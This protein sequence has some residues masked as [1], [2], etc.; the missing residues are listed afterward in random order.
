MMGL[1]RS[2]A[3]HLLIRWRGAVG[4]TEARGEEVK[5]FRAAAAG[6]V[7]ESRQRLLC[8]DRLALNDVRECPKEVDTAVGF[9]VADEQPLQRNLRLAELVF[10]D[11]LLGLDGDSTGQRGGH[12]AE[13]DLLRPS[14]SDGGVV[15]GLLLQRGCEARVV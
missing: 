4:R 13:H 1:K 5:L 11:G 14:E 10:A 7:D 12:L 8:F 2:A 9:L 3:V 15:L 6:S